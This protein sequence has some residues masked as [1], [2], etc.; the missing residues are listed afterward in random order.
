MLADT[1]LL[2]IDT[3]TNMFQE[4]MSVY[5]GPRILE[6]IQ[7]LLQRARSQGA[8]VF[9]LRNDGGPGEPDEYGTPGWQLHSSVTPQTGDVVIDKSSP[10]GF[11]DTPLHEELQGREI[12]KLVLV[13]MQ[14]EYCIDATARRAAEL[15]YQVVVVEDG[16]TTFDFEELTAAEAIEK[17]NHAL[18][19]VGRVVKAAAISFRG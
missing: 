12:R 7:V 16:H 13:G 1:A 11:Q 18:E 2:V 14:T 15:G 8:P 5:D 6:T 19:E 17:Y 9:Y 3:Q 4:E 10:N